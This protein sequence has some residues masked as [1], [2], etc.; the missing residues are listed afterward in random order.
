MDE[1]S[2]SEEEYSSYWVEWFLQ[3]KGNEYLCEVDEDFLSDRFNLT[4]LNSFVP[5]YS[6]ALDLINDNFG[7][8]SKKIDDETKR[9]VDDSAKKLYGLIHAR[10]IVTARGLLK[11]AEKYRQGD[12]GR[13]PRTLC[14]GACVLPHGQ[15]DYL[16]EGKVR[17][18]C[19]K[20]EDIYTPKSSRHSN[21][22]GAF[23]GTTFAPFFFLSYPNLI[24]RHNPNDQYTPRIFGFK[25]HHSAKVHR[26]QYRLMAP[27]F[28][29]QARKRLGLEKPRS[30]EAP[31]LGAAT[32]R[33]QKGESS[34]SAMN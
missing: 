27:E 10:F 3:T 8:D 16:G 2:N 34:P 25:V 33:A 6:M 13:C 24:P 29:L 30:V 1:F 11:M 22:D 26:L 17:L 23:F 4:G 31:A 14:K 7:N 20:C 28:Q 21:M 5:H 9:V 32:A 19:P 15:H 18:Y 12:F